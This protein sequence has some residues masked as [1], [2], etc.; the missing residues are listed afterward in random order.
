MFDHCVFYILLRRF[1]A[2]MELIK[3]DRSDGIVSLKGLEYIDVPA[4]DTKNYK[5]SFFT[6]K[7]GQY[8]AKASAIIHP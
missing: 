2:V 4:L 1:R 7:E 3:P 5:L 6:Y 8:N